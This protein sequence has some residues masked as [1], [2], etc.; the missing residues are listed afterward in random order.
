MYMVSFRLDHREGKLKDLFASC[1]FPYECANLDVGDVIILN[2]ND[3]VCV[4][5][6]KTIPDLLSSINDG[7]YKDQKQRLL[8]TYPTH[9]LFYVIEGSCMFNTAPRN[10]QDKTVH[11]AIINTMI[12]DH[13]C[14][15]CTKDVEE[16]YQLLQ[17]IAKRVHENPAKYNGNSHAKE[18]TVKISHVVRTKDA[19]TCYLN[20]LCQVPD[21]SIKTAEAIMQTYPSMASLYEACKGK[22]YQEKL[23]M[24]KDISTLDSKGKSRKLSSRAITNIV[25]Y[26][27]SNEHGGKD[28]TL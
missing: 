26:M 5:E 20:Q 17:C 19:K 25:T 14:T 10:Q 24:L 13:I 11:G 22:S 21:I 4:F 3:I 16:T 9:K 28:D 8:Q 2:D 6:R 15:F 1:S 23:N 7:R 27:L 18:E 12:R